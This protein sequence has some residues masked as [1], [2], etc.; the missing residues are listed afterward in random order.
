MKK[1]VLI[2]IVVILLIGG[3]I[4]SKP[5]KEMAHEPDKEIVSKRYVA[6]EGKVEAMSGLDIDVGSELIARLEQV[7]F[8][9][10]DFVKKGDVIVRLDSR[11][12]QA[13]LKEAEGE[14]IVTKAKLK[15]V[16]SGSREEEIKKAIASLEAAAADMDLA[17]TNLER[18]EQ[19]YKE[20]VIPKSILDEKEKIFKV[21]KARVKEA[22]EEK[23]LLEKGPKQETIKVYEDT[24]SR[25]NATVEYYKRLLE[26]TVIKSPISGNVI[27]KYLEEGE[28]V[29]PEKPILTIADVENIR[30]NA[31]VDE[32]D[33]GRIKI[34]DSVN[35]TSD[36]YP[37]KDF[38]GEVQE[39]SD[40][41]GIRNIK[42]NN[43]AKNIDMK[44]IQVKITLKEKT[45]FKIGMTVD[46]RIMPKGDR[47]E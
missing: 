21:A 16:V 14:F 40:Y 43:P 46:V 33:L 27:N 42:P 29:I 6:A 19:L 9:E 44:V 26:K 15:E 18:H 35:V 36:A 41:V 45:P 11:D 20:G 3:Y 39:I 1:L 24:A 28:T 32:T 38:K 12:I 47:Y 8:K 23:R 2:I 7:F 25:A 22:E 5:S 34:G 13:K 17:K 37:G 31:E 4:I 10:G 30:I